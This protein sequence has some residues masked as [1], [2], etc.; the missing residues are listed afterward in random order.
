MNGGS[1]AASAPP[2]ER[3]IERAL[4]LIVEGEIAPGE[5]AGRARALLNQWRGKSAEHAAAVQEARER[6]D[7]LGG[8]ANDLRAHFDE[9]EAALMAN[10]AAAAAA[11]THRQQRRKMLLS[12]AALLGTGLVAGRGVQWYWQQPVFRAAYETRTAQMLKVTLTDGR[13]GAPGSQLD[14][15]PQSAIDVALYR[16]HRAVDMAHGEVRFEVARD[17]DRP[18]RVRTRSATIEVVGTAFT[19]RDRGGPITVGVEHGHVRVHVSPRNESAGTGEEAIDLRVGDLLEIDDDRA[20]AVRQTDTAALSAWRNGWLVFENTPLGDALAAVNSYRAR[21][22]VS[23]NP[24]IDAMR[25]SGRFRTNDS[26]GLV[27]ALPTI[28][29]L[30]AEPQ[31]DGSVTL[32]T[33]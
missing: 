33:R 16:Q 18:F 17:A 8:M 32:R 3:L 4:A 5:A 6:W 23:T 10:A 9:P 28:L 15:A 25:L 24:R 20:A 31:P 30:A 13:S 22:I 2:R 19:V 7:A 1:M 14:L 21:P 12:V 26:D 27:A 11:S 29:P